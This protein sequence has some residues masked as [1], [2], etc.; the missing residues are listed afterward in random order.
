M[1][2]STSKN[3]VER[4]VAGLAFFPKPDQLKAM[5]KDF[6]P[7][8]ALWVEAK[9]P[10]NAFIYDSL[11]TLLACNIPVIDV[12]YFRGIWHRQVRLG[13]PKLV[14]V[15][16]PPSMIVPVMPAK[17]L[18]TIKGIRAADPKEHHKMSYQ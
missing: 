10:D 2:K 18:K 3:S 13:K 5:G 12:K 15:T 14:V 1:S 6:W 9:K 4:T 17:A 7:S 11:D 8:L 16:M